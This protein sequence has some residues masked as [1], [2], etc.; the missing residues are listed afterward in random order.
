MQADASCRPQVSPTAVSRFGVVT[1]LSQ[2][3]KEDQE[4]RSGSQIQLLLDTYPCQDPV[5]LLQPN[6]KHPYLVLQCHLTCSGCDAKSALHPLSCF[7]ASAA[8]NGFCPHLN[9]LPPAQHKNMPSWPVLGELSH[10]DHQIHA[11]PNG[12]RLE[13]TEAPA[14]PTCHRYHGCTEQL[15]GFPIFTM[16][17]PKSYRECARLLFENSIY[18]FSSSPAF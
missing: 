6:R 3:P 17:A 15:R 7:L 16:L 4:R 1:F 5:S 9:S 2:K 11:E 18:R 8:F 14:Y 10:G 12:G 13:L